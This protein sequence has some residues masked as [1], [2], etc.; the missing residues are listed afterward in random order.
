[1]VEELT[2]LHGKRLTE[3]LRDPETCLATSLAIM[4][5]YRDSETAVIHTQQDATM[6]RLATEVLEV[7]YADPLHSPKAEVARHMLGIEYECVLEFYLRQ[8]GEYYLIKL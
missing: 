8:M 2:Q 5:K 3:A 4:E 6:T 7:Q 1:M